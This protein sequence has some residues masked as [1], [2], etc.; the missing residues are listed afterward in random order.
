MEMHGK[1]L[2]KRLRVAPKLL[3]VEIDLNRVCSFMH[4]QDKHKRPA[5]GR[6]DWKAFGLGK[7]LYARQMF[8][9]PED[10]NPWVVDRCLKIKY[11]W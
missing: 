2:S 6:R 9:S 4:D 3:G 10:F 7:T 5:R 11:G 1:R 8:E